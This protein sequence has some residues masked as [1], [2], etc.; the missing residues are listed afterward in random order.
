MAP[1]SGKG[2]VGNLRQPLTALGAGAG[3]GVDCV[4]GAGALGAG[5][6]AAGGGAGGAGGGVVLPASCRWA[7]LIVERNRT[8]ANHRTEC[9]MKHLLKHTA[10]A[11]VITDSTFTLR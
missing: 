4:K 8:A 11:A 6:D 7:K 5:V 2:H 3:A 10:K 9:L 1:A